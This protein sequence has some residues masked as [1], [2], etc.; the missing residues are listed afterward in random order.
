MNGS[1]R[2]KLAGEGLAGLLARLDPTHGPALGPLVVRLAEALGR[3]HPCLPA[4]QDGPESAALAASP[5]VAR[6]DGAFRPLV[7]DGSRLYLHRYWELECRLAS[8]LRELAG[9]GPTGGDSDADGQERVV[10]LAQHRAL[11]LLAGGPGTG[12]TTTVRRMLEALAQGGDH[13]RVALAAPTGKAARRLSES[14]AEAAGLT[15]APASTLH[16][17]LGIRP[18]GPP[19]FHAGNPLPHDL[20]V[21][22]EASMIDLV[23]MARL[24]DALGP[25]T[26]LILIGDP[27]QL[28]SV[29]VGSVFGDLVEAAEAG[30]P[31]A[32]CLV[33]LHK[34]YRFTAEL[35]A[36]CAAVRTGDL[37]R[38]L[39][40]AGG[41]L[42]WREFPP[43]DPL[44]ESPAAA[45]L[46]AALG[47]P[48]PTNVL[49][50]LA[51]ARLLTA[52]REGPTGVRGLAARA[53]VRF[54][55]GGR[56]PILVTRNAPDRQLYNGDVGFL[57]PSGTA[58]FTAADGS[59]R[60]VPA[61]RLPAHETA[62]ALT[63]HRSQGSEFDH[64][65][66]VL[67]AA[68]HPLLTRELVYTAISRA[69]VSVLLDAP[70]AVLA[71][72][73]ARRADR[74]SGLA[75]RLR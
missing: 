41:A 21:V 60:A 68:D 65:H 7:L 28:A 39:E 61:V 40:C 53:A 62:W 59:P 58:W 31:L 57:D 70:R 3:Q 22:D 67:P 63:V 64:V 24:V 19:R 14:L 18:D 73:L 20:V 54:P 44:A 8:R 16:R 74:P 36:A 51:R 30:G 56:T 5:L 47:E 27:D 1:D 10:A 9:R 50:G 75:D 72:A 45:A 29:E 15:L 48:E 11:L 71:A 12:K 23:V 37:D 13:P 6:G 25:T 26:R 46:G 49:A 35:A 17:L 38:L 43:Q 66:L 32:P 33:R 55:S 2:H 4:P 42:A 52:F 34:T 69:R